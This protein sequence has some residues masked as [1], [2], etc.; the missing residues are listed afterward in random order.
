VAAWWW[1]WWL[2]LAAVVSATAPRRPKHQ[3]VVVVVAATTPWIWSWVTPPPPPRVPLPQI[4]VLGFWWVSIVLQLGSAWCASV[5]VSTVSR[6]PGRSRWGLH[7]L[8]LHYRLSLPLPPSI[9]VMKTSSAF[10]Q[11]G[12]G[13]GP[14]HRWRKVVPG[15]FSEKWSGLRVPSANR[16]VDLGRE[17]GAF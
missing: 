16:L 4:L 6:V 12:R 13:K 17:M 2:H 10:M 15:I 8:L 11:L 14:N 5:L 1:L 7:R 3:S 9:P